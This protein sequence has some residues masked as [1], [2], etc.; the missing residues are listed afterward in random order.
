MESEER[1]K[2]N[3]GKKISSENGGKSVRP[4]DLE[5]DEERLITESTSDLPR[6]QI[7]SQKPPRVTAGGVVS[8]FACVFLFIGVSALI[9][10]SQ[11][12]SS[13]SLTK[14][15]D[16]ENDASLTSTPWTKGE[17][18][19]VIDSNDDVGAKH[20]G[21]PLVDDSQ[22]E[23]EVEPEIDS[24]VIDENARKDADI[25]KNISADD[26]KDKQDENVEKQMEESSSG[27]DGYD[28]NDATKKGAAN[29]EEEDSDV[30]DATKEARFKFMECIPKQCFGNKHFIRRPERLADPR[31][32]TLL[33]SYPGSG[34]TWT[35]S[36]SKFF[37]MFLKRLIHSFIV[38]KAI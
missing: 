13:S 38:S 34:N 11:Q 36:I 5:A 10:S 4:S 6:G 9:G 26:G 24:S 35:R 37:L 30:D 23:E 18:E 19:Q 12:Q 3:S 28:D 20:T 16:E 29:K 15:T 7:P 14:Q 27:D 1:E 2:L 33:A 8:L 21:G 22:E 17:E 32:F 25:L 31:N